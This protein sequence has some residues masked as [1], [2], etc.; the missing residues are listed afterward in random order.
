MDKPS[1]SLAFVMVKESFAVPAI[2]FYLAVTLTKTSIR[3][4]LRKA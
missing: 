1:F 4:T 3:T 2:L